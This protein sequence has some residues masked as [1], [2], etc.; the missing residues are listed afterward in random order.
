MMKAESELNRELKRVFGPK[1]I[2]PLKMRNRAQFDAAIAAREG[3]KS[4]W[5]RGYPALY[6]TWF[7][8]TASVWR[9]WKT[10]KE[11][12]LPNKCCVCLAPPA[13]YLPVYREARIFGLRHKKEIVLNR[14][15]HCEQHGQ[16][17]EAQLVVIFEEMT[18]SAVE[19]GVIGINQSFLDE[20]TTLNKVG[21]EFPPW[22]A[23]PEYDS[24]TPA[25]RQ[26][27]GEYWMHD[28]WWPFWEQLSWTE[29]AAYLDRWDASEDWREYLT[30]VY[31][32]LHERPTET[33]SDE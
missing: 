14:A 21:D 9:K 29:R 33:K 6:S 16:R 31:S 11:V 17:D 19:I 32:Y 7:F 8:L 24:F 5:D 13:F 27:A 20:V 4:L 22:E 2:P 3:D 10:E 25:W 1:T 30:T 12:W 18:R 15:P 28:A 26:G 23:F